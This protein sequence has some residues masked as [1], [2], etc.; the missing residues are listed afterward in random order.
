ML[1]KEEKVVKFQ[2]MLSKDWSEGRG[3]EVGDVEVEWSC[4][5]KP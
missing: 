5:T 3:Q 2:E 1:D 4:L